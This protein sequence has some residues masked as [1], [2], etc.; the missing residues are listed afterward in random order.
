KKIA[1]LAVRKVESQATIHSETERQ[2][3]CREH[4]A[5]GLAADRRA[6]RADGM[7]DCPSN[8]QPRDRCGRLL[9]ADFRL[10]LGIVAAGSDRQLG[11]VAQSPGPCPSARSPPAAE[12]RKPS[13]GD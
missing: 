7:A 5:H 1:N 4:L 13:G 2:T 11:A 9:S 12:A 10:G 6:A 3:P 8:A